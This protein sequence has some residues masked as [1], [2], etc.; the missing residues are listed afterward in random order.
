MNSNVSNYF[1]FNT[2]V[3][4]QIK[5]GTKSFAMK[6][7][8]ITLYTVFLFNC[9]DCQQ[10]IKRSCGKVIPVYER[11]I[12]IH[13]I[14]NNNKFVNM[15][16]MY[17]SSV[18][19]WCIHNDLIHNQSKIVPSS[20]LQLLAFWVDNFGGIKIGNFLKESDAMLFLLYNKCFLDY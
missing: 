10:R 2:T 3:P 15:C 13:F 20:N 8:K 16:I 12:K 14:P 9:S 5:D 1:S 7:G 19:L 18:F 6:R 17:S 4:G 11:Q